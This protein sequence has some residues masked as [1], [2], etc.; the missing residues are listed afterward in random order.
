L[1]AEEMRKEILSSVSQNGGHLASNLGMVEATIAVHRV[2]DSPNDSIIFDVGHQCYAHK[3]LSGRR[4]AL[5]ELRQAG[6]ASGFTNPN[7]SIHDK[8]YAGHC[9]TS[10]STA[11]GMATSNSLQNSKN[12][13]VAIVGDGAFTNGMIY[14]ALNNCI[15]S[16]LRLIIILND[17]EMAISKN[18]GGL[19]TFLEKTRVSRQYFDVKHSTESALCSIPYIGNAMA[20]SLRKAKDIMRRTFVSDN[21]FE[22]LGIDYLGPVD[23]H[24]IEKLEFVLKEAKRRENCC[25]VHIRTQK[26]KGYKP[27]I[28]HPELYHSVGTFNL[29]CGISD[30]ANNSFSSTFGQIMCKEAKENPV[31]CAITAAMCDG[32]GLSAF[33]K[34]FPR[35]FFD[36]GIAEEHAVAFSGGLALS[37]MYPVCA[38][39]S[40]FA[41]RVFDQ[42]FHDVALQKAHVLFAL[43][44]CGLVPGDGATHQGIF[45]VGLFSAIPNI[46]IYSPETYIE[47]ATVMHDAIAKKELCVVRYPKGKEH[48][49]KKAA[50]LTSGSFIEYY[51]FNVSTEIE[52]DIVIITYGRITRSALSAISLM[53]SNFSIRLVKL[54]RIFPINLNELLPLIRSPRLLYLLEEGAYTGGISEKICAMLSQS[55]N[56]ITRIVVRAIENTFIPHGSLNDLDKLCGFLPE[57]ISEEITSNMRRNSE[58]TS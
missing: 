37:G 5:A 33:S 30:G 39:Y 47:L 34:Q 12:Y 13:V 41:Q 11:I 36:V 55:N 9:G 7:E 56:R 16:N 17:N 3:L 20:A 49:E 45:D 21:M 29:E 1:L 53:S 28:E 58:I 14:E 35:R 42:V 50:C 31:L 15:N 48:V 32:T 43:D 26:G 54:I 10:I 8:T 19:S 2:F 46:S 4:D 27:A 24:N 6:G 38:L 22:C 51:D 40:T 52:S 25:V 23:G 57:Q 18:V 44:R